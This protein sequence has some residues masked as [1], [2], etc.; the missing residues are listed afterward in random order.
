MAP[1]S[2][3]D[4]TSAALLDPAQQ[5][6]VTPPSVR[7]RE[8]RLARCARIVREQGGGGGE[9]RAEEEVGVNYPQDEVI[10]RRQERLARERAE[11]AGRR[12]ALVYEGPQDEGLLRSDGTIDWTVLDRAL[13]APTTEATVLPLETLAQIPLSTLGF[14]SLEPILPAPSLPALPS[15]TPASS[16][17]SNNALPILLSSLYLIMRA[18]G[19]G[20]SSTRRNERETDTDRKVTVPEGGRRRPTE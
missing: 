2:S 17:L 20:E 9:V 6:C 10:Q 19:V 13:Q 14:P 15:S 18:L 1:T 5:Q 4:R 7:R 12:Q 11:R 16:I 8:A 3:S